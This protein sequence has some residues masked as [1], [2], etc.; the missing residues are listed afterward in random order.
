MKRL[1]LSLLLV[2]AGV[3]YSQGAVVAG[4]NSDG[5]LPAND[6]GSTGFVSFGF[7]TPINFFGTSYTGAY[8]NNNGNLTF[9]S[10]QM[11][12][13]PYGLT[14]HLGAGAIIAPFF[15]DVDT[16]GSG[17]DLLRYGSGTY[18]GRDAFGVTWAGV[19][20]GYYNG[21]T[22]KLNSFQVLLV[23]RSDVN[24][25]DFDIVF[26]YDQIQWESGDAS[27]G[28]DGLGGTSA[29]VGFSNGTGD[30]GTY[31]QLL[32]SLVNGAFLDGGP[33]A[34]VTGAYNSDVA[35]SYTFAVR[36]GTPDVVTPE[37]ATITIWALL[38]ATS[39]LGMRVWRKPRS[40]GRHAWSSETRNAIHEIIARGNRS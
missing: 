26:N 23:D 27:G 13:T 7:A 30:A 34:L 20:V 5:Y 17:S 32:G 29:A 38:G 1:V 15:A 40:A 10:P 35:G 21:N 12:Y 18:N 33:N 31:F 14:T 2:F 28:T 6:D 37:P 22:D 3:G 4:F 25:G 39:W 36:N 11:T 9:S 16:R 8:L 19:G 24:A